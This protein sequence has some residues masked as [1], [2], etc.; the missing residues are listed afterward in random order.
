MTLSVQAKQEAVVYNENSD[1]PLYAA[2]YSKNDLNVKSNSKRVSSVYELKGRVNKTDPVQKIRIPLSTRKVWYDRVLL[3][4]FDKEALLET[5]TY[6]QIRAIKNKEIMPLLGNEYHVVSEEDALTIY[7]S[8]EWKVIL[9]TIEKVVTPIYK[10]LVETIS[11]E[12]DDKE[13]SVRV[14]DDLAPEELAYFEKRRV[15]SKKSLETFLNMKLEDADVPNVFICFSGGGYRAMTGSCGAI[16]ALIRLGLWDVASY[17]SGLSG[18]TWFLGQYLALSAK[19]KMSFDDIKKSL[20]KKIQKSLFFPSD[21]VTGVLDTALSAKILTQKVILNQDISSIDFF[22]LLL[23]NRFLT[24]LGG[25]KHIL[26]FSGCAD[27]VLSNNIPF[28]IFTGLVANEQVKDWFEVTVLEFGC[29]KLKVFIPIWAL[30]RKFVAGV[31]QDFAPE[32]GLGFL[33]AVF[34]SAISFTA[35]EFIKELQKAIP[36]AEKLKIVTQ[37]K[38]VDGV[39]FFPAKVK[40]PTYGMAGSP[41]KSES[42]LI[43]VD[44]GMTQIGIPYRPIER[45]M[46]LL[47]KHGFSKANIVIICDYSAGAIG[48]NLK[49]IEKDAQKRGV[50][51]P[52]LGPVESFSNKKITVFKG[53]IAKGLPTIIYMPLIKNETYSKTFDPKKEE[54]K[55]FCNTF[56]LQYTDKQFDVLS[57]LAKKNLEDCEETIR[58][59]IKEVIKEMATAKAV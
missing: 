54:A 33:M 24:E 10:G 14:G 26:G 38:V 53:D 41:V 31:S 13:A 7:N 21:I 56:T 27:Y 47:E 45:R 35:K 4:T 28:L 30:D 17:A 44:A 57:G 20:R 51:F 39:R 23:S 22:G 3:V 18:S 50:A 25:K 42:K 34:G 59:T 9:P 40:N 46:K 36:S 29:E 37:S 2:L 43:L 1:K 16:E 32:Q 5:L 19:K 48:E 12:Y 6:K 49:R 52:I 11:H 8:P 58:N 55:G 15:S